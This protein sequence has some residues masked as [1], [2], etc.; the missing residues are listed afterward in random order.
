MW[1]RDPSYPGLD[2]KKLQDSLY[3]VRIGL[4]WRAVALEEDDTFVWTFIGSHADY[5]KLGSR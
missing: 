3:S 2:F 1:L 4:H 5:D